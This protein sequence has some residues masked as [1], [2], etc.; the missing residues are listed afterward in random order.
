MKASASGQKT[1]GPL[2]QA[3]ALHGVLQVLQKEIKHAKSVYQ[4]QQ[5]TSLLLQ[6]SDSDG[7]A[8]VE[9]TVIL[10]YLAQKYTANGVRL[11][12]SDAA[13]AAKVCSLTA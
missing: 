7:T 8:V 4:R 9:S 2:G 13:L 11:I 6:P 1:I 12:P 3:A 5:L 10:E